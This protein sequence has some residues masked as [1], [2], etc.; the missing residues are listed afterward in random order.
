MNEPAVLRL[1]RMALIGSGGVTSAGTGSW[2][3]QEAWDALI[4][5]LDEVDSRTEI[6][7]CLQGTW[8]RRP[9]LRR[10]L[11]DVLAV[12]HAEFEKDGQ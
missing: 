4:Y 1:Y 5:V 12:V 8:E 10:E 11:D 6:I 9:S 7:R 2:A 3:S